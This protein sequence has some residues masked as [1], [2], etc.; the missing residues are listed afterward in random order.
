[1]A[2]GPG[3]MWRFDS[4]PRTHLLHIP[5]LQEGG[6]LTTST[7][8]S[9]SDW[10]TLI[11]AITAQVSVSTVVGVLAAAA[12]GAIGFVFLWWGGRKTVTMLMAA[13]KRG[14]LKI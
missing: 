10:A 4:A 13:F 6:N 2:L 12:T 14:K 8:I 3:R 11:S 1:M 5:A 9:P 7:V